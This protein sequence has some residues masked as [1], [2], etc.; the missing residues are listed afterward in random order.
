MRLGIMQ[1]YIF[2]FWGYYQLIAATDRFIVYDDVSYI[3]Q[4]WINRNRILLNGEPFSFT[5]PLQD[6]GSFKAIGQTAL[7]PKSFALWRGKFYKTLTQA[8]RK[9]PYFEPAMNLVTKVLDDPL[10]LTISQLATTSLREVCDYLNIGTSFASSAGRYNNTHLAAQV[11][12]LDICA[13]EGASTYINAIGG[14]KLYN[15]DDFKNRGLQLAF[16]ESQPLDYTQFGRPMVGSLSIIDVLMFNS[17]N[18]LQNRLP[19]FKLLTK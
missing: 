11:R 16:L 1:P 5:V 3:K 15:F 19:Q 4:G 13:I 14:Q 9:A 12:I 6:A 8:Y 7:D 10:H 17:S 2:P 18:E